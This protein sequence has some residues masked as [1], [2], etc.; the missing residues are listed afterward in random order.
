MP[1]ADN[2]H[3]KHLKKQLNEVEVEI[4]LVKEVVMEGLK[5]EEL[6]D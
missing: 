6:S 2:L 3:S 4:Q 5:E 1:A